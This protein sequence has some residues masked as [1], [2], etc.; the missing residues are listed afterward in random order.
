MCEIQWLLPKLFINIFQ[1]LCF[2]IVK[3]EPKTFA[4]KLKCESKMMGTRIMKVDWCET[5]KS[6]LVLTKKVKLDDCALLPSSSSLSHPPGSRHPCCFM[7]FYVIAT[8]LKILTSFPP[9]EKMRKHYPPGL[10]MTSSKA[11]YPLQRP[12]KYYWLILSTPTWYYFFLN[13]SK[14]CLY[15]HTITNQLIRKFKYLKTILNCG[16]KSSW[17]S[18]GQQEGQ[19]NQS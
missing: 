9:L 4:K 18:L 16:I 12:C 17:E 19:T 15:L 11:W 1:L 8:R 14:F 10:M 3:L 2:M 6:L 7:W 13:I 5:H